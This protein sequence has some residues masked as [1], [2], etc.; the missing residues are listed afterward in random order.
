ME[1]IINY[2]T[3]RLSSEINILLLLKLYTDNNLHIVN[4]TENEGLKL[5]FK[6]ILK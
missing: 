3:P 5:T 2:T 4:V 1:Q 6:F